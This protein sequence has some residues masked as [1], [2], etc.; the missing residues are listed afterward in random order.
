M[1]DASF[2]QTSF[3]G[4]EWAPYMQGRFDRQDYRTAMNVCLNGVPVEEGSWTRRGGTRRLAPTR[5]GQVGVLREFHFAESAPYLI[6]FTPFHMRFFAGT[7]LVLDGVLGKFVV[8]GISATNPAEVATQ[9]PHG[10][11]TGDQVQFEFPSGVSI[12]SAARLMEKQFSITVTDPNHFTLANPIT[13]AGI[14]GAGIDLGGNQIL[15]GRVLDLDTN[16]PDSVLQQI[17]VVQGQDTDGSGVALILRAT[18]RPIALRTASPPAGCVPATFD[19]GPADFRDGPYMD[20]IADGSTITVTATGA[21]V[22]FSVTPGSGTGRPGFP[23]FDAVKDPGR[24]IRLRYEPDDWDNATSYAAGD[25]V[26]FADTYWTANVA[27]TG[28]QPDLDV[29]NWS[30]DPSIAYWTW[31]EIQSVSSSTDI[32]VQI[33]GNR[34]FGPG[35]VGVVIRQWRLGL[36]SEATEWPRNGTF[37]EGRL[38]LGG[39]QDNRFDGSKSNDFFNFAPTAEDGTVADDNAISYVLNTKDV[40]PI[41]WMDPDDQG[42]VMGTKGGEFHTRASQLSDPLTPTS[43]QSKRV[44]KYGCANIEPRRTGLSLCMVQKD[45]KNVIEYVPDPTPGKYSG[46]NM[47]LKG[48]HLTHPGVEELAYV[49]L[50]TP[51]LWARTS[52]GQLIGCTYKR[53]NPY[54]TQPE[55][56][57]GWHRHELAD[58]QTIVNSIAAGPSPDGTIDSLY[59]VTVGDDGVYWVETL[60]PL[61]EQDQDPLTAWHLDHAIRPRAAE[62]VSYGM[63]SADYVRLWGLDD[64]TGQDVDVWGAALD[65]GTFTVQAGGYIDVPVDAT[66]SLFTSAYLATLTAESD[67]FTG[68]AVTIRRAQTGSVPQPIGSNLINW[69]DP[70]FPSVS[71]DGAAV[72]WDAGFVWIAREGNTGNAL[73]RYPLAGGSVQTTKT[74]TDIFGSEGGGEQFVKKPI[75]YAADGVSLLWSST[76]SNSGKFCKFNTSTNTLTTLGSSNASLTNTANHIMSGL[77]QS[78]L[79]A[80]DDYVIVPS[81]VGSPGIP[82][83]CSVAVINTTTMAFFDAQSLDDQRGVSCQGPQVSFDCYHSGTAYVLGGEKPSLLLGAGFSTPLSI[84]SYTINVWG[85][86]TPSGTLSKLGGFV[87]SDVAGDWTEF[88]RWEGLIFDGSDGNVIAAVHTDNAATHQ[89]YLVKISTQDGSILW[90]TPVS[91]IPASSDDFN[92]SRLINGRLGYIT[93]SNLYNIDTSDGSVVTSTATGVNAG[94]KGYDDVT[95]RLQVYATSFSQSTGPQATGST[96]TSF[97]NHWATFPSTGTVAHPVYEAPFVVGFTYTSDGQ[98]VRPVHPNEAGAANGPALAKTRR[99]HQFAAVLHKTRGVSFGTQFTKLRPVKM[100]TEGGTQLTLLQLYSG[101]YW[102]TLEDKYTFDS[103]LCWRT[104]RPYPTTVLAVGNFLHTQD[105]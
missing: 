33:K 60:T 13:G 53:D 40:N 72:N 85:N 99:A 86:G 16:Y 7:S 103:M 73:L 3:L 44:T 90:A 68:L 69:Y 61:F 78:P 98:I 15:V 75:S 25:H 57:S 45:V 70:G 24:L 80:G 54:G 51:I 102:D 18:Q 34:T 19:I 17:R 66:G 93:G 95:G 22:D 62:I 59:M 23:G 82:D 83:P 91:A 49:A 5:S 26:K 87:P 84:Y 97:T 89:D 64:Y 4:G 96:P 35:H 76:S 74:I 94:F 39:A 8:A 11:T 77:T 55:S 56:F 10:M 1:P 100:T 104:T 38:W 41:L 30:I 92:I 88:H 67:Q 101:T 6:E 20:L 9:Q 27:N 105:R 2:T 32:N 37:H 14:D 47:S 52:E 29:V 28:K 48:K 21:G 58:P 79:T 31:G 63:P 65:L 46:Q 81:L 50:T 43:V 36:Y 71:T 42:I 12:P